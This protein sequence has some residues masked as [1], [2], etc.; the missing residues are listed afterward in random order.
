MSAE[1]AG[2]EPDDAIRDVHHVAQRL[3][4]RP[5]RVYE[6]VEAG[7]LGHYKLGHRTLRFSDQH[8]AEYLASVEVEVA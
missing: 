7:K 6:L 3:G 5:R 8:I 4:V 1:A 2:V